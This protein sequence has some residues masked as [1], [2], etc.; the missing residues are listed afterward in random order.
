MAEDWEEVEEIEELKYKG[1][2][3]KM[4]KDE[5]LLK[6]VEEVFDTYMLEAIYK[7]I[8]RKVIDLFY[9]V[10]DTGKESRVYW[11]KSPRGEDLAV[12]IFLTS[13]REFRRTILQYIDGG[14]RFKK[15]R[16][17]TRP[18][19]YAWALKEFKNLKKAYEAGVS[20]PKPIAV[21]RNVIVMSFVGEEGVPAPLLKDVELD[22]Y[23]EMFHKVVDNLKKLYCKAELVHADMSEYNI[24]VWNEEPVFFDFGQAVLATHPNADVFLERDVNNLVNFFRKRGVKADPKAIL[25][26]I[27]KC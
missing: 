11:A 18:L 15:I 5:D 19:I 20:V 25:L 14:P 6:T 27:L 17:G 7:L 12:K 1:K 24:M 2:E 26:D 4:R 9:G 23:E 21:Y 8:N 22:G 10:V 16:R 13:T 3:E